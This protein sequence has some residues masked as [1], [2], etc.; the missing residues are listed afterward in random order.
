M[1]PDYIEF[2]EN[3][4]V[5]PMY[6]KASI[7]EL[8]GTI[9]KIFNMR[10]ELKA[11]DEEIFDYSLFD[12]IDKLIIIL[13]DALGYLYLYKNFTKV[14]KKCRY[15]TVLTSTAPSTTSTAIMSIVYGL[16]PLEHGILGYHMYLERI[17]TV[18]NILKFSPLINPQRESLKEYGFNSN[19]L[20]EAK[21]VFQRLKENEINSVKIIPDLL[22]E[23][24]YTELTSKGA[25]RL[26]YFTLADLFMKILSK[27]SED[28][29]KV[30]VAYWGGL[31][32]IEHF[33]GVDSD[34]TKAEIELFLYLLNNWLL[35]RISSRSRIV[36]ISDHGQVNVSRYVHLEECESIV[37]NL[38]LPPAGESRFMMLF[39]R[40]EEDIIN[41]FKS[42]Y[43]ENIR[44]FTKDEV[45]KYRLFG[46][47]PFIHRLGDVFI[48]CIRDLAFTYRLKKEEKVR[49]LK[50]LHGSLTPNEMLVPLIIF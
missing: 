45:M 14:L 46:E 36:L 35:P 9:L 12:N 48:A 23:T 20:L 16:K 3:N 11:L 10:S 19:T 7:C 13:I 26:G 38:I 17:G 15:Y 40:N 25:E 1:I 43:A 50:G 22:L 47:G 30:I 31:D 41:Y 18:V 21:T 34:E 24:S 37:K 44:V 2:L 28:N 5:K 8:A 27:I 4:I 42:K 29:T 33:Y 49:E 6:N 32:T 39:V